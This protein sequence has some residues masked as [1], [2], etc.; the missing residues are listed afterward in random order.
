ML[1]LMVGLVPI[2]PAFYVL[3]NLDYLVGG[4]LD[5]SIEWSNLLAYT[6]P[7][8]LILIVV[9]MAI[10]IAARWAIFP[11]RVK[12]GSYS[13]YSS[14]YYRKW[15]LALCTE[16]VLE[17]LNSLFA[18]VYMRYWY[19]AM[20]ARIGKGS[21]ISTNL[22]GRYDLV[23][24]GKG[25]FIGDEAIFGDEEIRNGYMTLATVKTGDRV[26]FGNA[27]IVPGGTQIEDGALIGVKSKVPDTLRVGRDETWFGSPAIKFPTRQKVTWAR[28]RPMSRRQ[29]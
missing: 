24:I 19:R 12:P 2:F 3:Y 28:T 21:E 8:A 13:I 14:F 25:N 11:R 1:V 18:T 26:F 9:S 22:A 29:G 20:G 17:T 10:V 4:E 16:V 5:Y 7:T 27:A 23:E 15:T 6:W